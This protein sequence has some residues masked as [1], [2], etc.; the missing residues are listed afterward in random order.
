MPLTRIHGVA[1][2][3]L[4]GLSALLCAFVASCYW[5]RLDGCAA[6]TFLPP[7]V[8]PAPGLALAGL[9]WRGGRRAVI[10]VL[11]LWCLFLI[12]VPEESRSLARLRRWPSPT[13]EQAHA[14]GQALRVISLNCGMEGTKAAAEVVQHDPDIVLLQETPAKAE[15]EGL[16]RRLYGSQAGLA[17]GVDTDIIARGTVTAVPQSGKVPFAYIEADVRLVS[18]IEAQVFSAHFLPPVMRFDVWSPSCWRDHAAKRAVHREQMRELAAAV[19]AVPRRGP[20]ILGGDF[21]VPGGDAIFRLLRPRLHDAFKEG[22]LGWGN[23]VLNDTP[24]SRF[25]QIWVSGEFRA[26]A[27]VARETK[28]SDHRMV[29]CDLIVRDSSR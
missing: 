27:L 24:V 14:R 9:G 5:L 10:A 7:W 16:A 20:V 1:Q 21:N 8:W 4:L 3:G 28:H 26:A 18:G 22:G 6:V 2:T 29:I 19:T 25:D 11:L 15:V 17:R 13:W 23:T 12:A